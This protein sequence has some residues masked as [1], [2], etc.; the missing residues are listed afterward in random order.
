MCTIKYNLHLPNPTPLIPLT[1]YSPSFILICLFD[2][3]LNP[4]NTTHVC[5]DVDTSRGIGSK[6]MSSS[7]CTIYW[8]TEPFLHCVTLLL[9]QSP[10]NC[11][12]TAPIL[13]PVLVTVALSNVAPALFFFVVL[14]VTSSLSFHIKFRLVDFCKR[15]EW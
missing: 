12:R 15:A 10:V 3:P 14:R 5:T 6:R 11:V 1:A 9:H 2:N 13:P 8:D 4:I 7:L